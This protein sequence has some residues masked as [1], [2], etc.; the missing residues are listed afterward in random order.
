MSYQDKKATDETIR[1]D[2]RDDTLY[3]GRKQWSN[4]CWA[5]EFLRRNEKYQ[6][7]CKTIKGPSKVRRAK[8]AAE[9]GRCD[10]KMYT[11]SYGVKEDSEKHWL[12]ETVLR[13]K[14]Y[15]DRD[16]EEQVAMFA[17]QPGDVAMVFNLKHTEIGG[18]AAVTSQIEYAKKYLLEKVSNAQYS[19]LGIMPTGVKRPHKEIWPTLLR[20]YDAKIRYDAPID[21]IIDILYMSKADKGKQLSA[22]EKI[23]YRKTISEHLKLAKG[24]VEYRYLSLIPLDYVQDKPQPEDKDSTLINT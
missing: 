21:E 19:E 23:P 22:Q 2:W 6:E 4:R 20:L 13:L 15:S 5:W 24:M 17:L 16:T 10:L 12:S 9:F 11:Q 18:L 3:E 1:T 7:V 8:A 14:A